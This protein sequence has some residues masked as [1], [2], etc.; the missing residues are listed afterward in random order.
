[1][2]NNNALFIIQMK[3]F[4][5]NSDICIRITKAGWEHLRKRVTEDYITHCILPYEVV[6]NGEIWYR[7]QLWSAF[8]LLPQKMGLE[9]LFESNI[10]LDNEDLMEFE[11]KCD[12]KLEIQ[13]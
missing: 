2:F 7:I 4:N 8:D 3:K 10:L 9:L 12:L 13:T 1:M 11:K 6:I 5:I